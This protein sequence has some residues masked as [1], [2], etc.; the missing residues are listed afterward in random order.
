MWLTALPLA[1]LGYTLNKQEFRDAVHLRYGWRIAD[2]PIHCS[3]GDRNDIDHA[4]A[5]KRGGYV[6]FR[7][8]K[9]RDLNA[10]LLNQV[11]KDVKT[12]P[13]LLPLQSE[14]LEHTGNVADGARLDV[15]AVGFW[16]PLQRTMFDVRIF[17][18]GAASYRDLDIKELYK[19][20]ETEKNGQ[21]RERVTQVEKA[22]FT[23]LIYSTNGGMAPE[24]TR[25][26]KRL[27]GLIAMKT[28]EDYSDVIQYLRT[29]TCFALLK[30][31]LIAVRGVRGKGPKIAEANPNEISF[32]LIPVF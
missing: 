17:H 21:Y 11:C 10:D 24:T 16:G 4:L 31:I 29:R 7:H 25:F 27:A 6:V 15:S 9:I 1:N 32:N 23:P 8:N 3:C 12:E 2:M 18:P 5:C 13:P 28:R 14:S 20:H 22:T 30:S 26:Q 19:R